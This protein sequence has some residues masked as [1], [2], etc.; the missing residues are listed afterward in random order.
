MTIRQKA[1]ASKNK[2]RRMS[3]REKDG[4]KVTGLTTPR[5]FQTSDLTAPDFS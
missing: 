4:L 2:G 1:V 3:G 5:P